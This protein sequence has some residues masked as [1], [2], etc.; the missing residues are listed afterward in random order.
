MT[1]I[2]GR[3]SSVARIASIPFFSSFSTSCAESDAATAC[4]SSSSFDGVSA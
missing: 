3:L 4:A 2:G 1:P